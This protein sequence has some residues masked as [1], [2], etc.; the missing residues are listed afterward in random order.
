MTRANHA[1]QAKISAH[2]TK[3]KILWARAT[4]VTHAKVL[5]IHAAQGARAAR[6][7]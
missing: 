2:A 3:A 4:H 7:I 5:W 1:T 6:A